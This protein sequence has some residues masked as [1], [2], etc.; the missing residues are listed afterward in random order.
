[1][2]KEDVLNLIRRRLENCE[3][4]LADPNIGEEAKT[5]QDGYRTALKDVLDSVR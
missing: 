3:Y 1:M 5:W 2:T 4:N